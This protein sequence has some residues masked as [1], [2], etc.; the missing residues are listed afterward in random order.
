MKPKKK[1]AKK[2]ILKPTL[3]QK[4][5][6][7]AISENI[8]KA[9][10]PKPM[11][12]LMKEAGY[13]DSMSRD[14]AKIISSPTFLDLLEKAGVSDEKLAEKL[15]TGLNVKLRS[16][17]SYHVMHKFMDTG[18]KIRK[19]LNPMGEEIID[20]F[21]QMVQIHLPPKEPLPTE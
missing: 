1:S 13:S 14:P 15:S 21:K 18:L 3:K 5:L 6:V 2:V 10:P 16:M 8:G 20:A 11:V 12:Q 9:G 7:K 4:R 19:H 17:A